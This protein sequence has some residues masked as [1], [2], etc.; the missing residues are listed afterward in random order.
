MMSKDQMFSVLMDHQAF[1]MQAHGGVSRIFAEIARHF[2]KEDL[3]LTV[4]GG[5]HVNEYLQVLQREK[6]A[7]TVGVRIPHRIGKQR[8]LMP[9]DK[10][11]LSLFCAAHRPDLIHY[12]YFH[13]TQP[14]RRSVREIMTVHD[15][16]Y[17][18]FPEYFHP[19]DPTPGRKRQMAEE[20]DGIICIS[21]N[22]KKDLLRFCDVPEERVR[23]IP[24]GNPMEGVKARRPQRERPPFFLF[25]GRR[26][27]YK[28]FTVLLDA[29]ASAVLC[30]GCEVVAFGGGPFT[31]N[32][33]RDIQSRGL[34]GCI[35]QM[36][37]PD[38]I[39]S[40]LYETAQALVYPSRYEGFG[41]PPLEAMSRGC[42]VIVSQGSSL[43]EVVGDA[44]LYF[45]PDD[46]DQLRQQMESLCTPSG[47]SRWVDK[48]LA[49]AKLFSW[50][51]CAR[52]TADFY[53]DVLAMPA[54]EY[55]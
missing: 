5:A 13:R 9:C 16:T 52:A 1:V 2:P 42:P 10:I 28:N 49:Q 48:G 38:E 36:S 41:L 18:L 54:R 23:V 24:H 14:R 35:F 33:Q 40:G 34:G 37:G 27:G 22:T 43:P 53:R 25:V 47:R 51:R 30:A 19:D 44:G 39:L 21:E 29:L 6:A 7:N 45:N 8:L 17:E 55:K 32:E 26:L 11:L 31:E 20:V 50:T 3:D 12:T 46:A 4:F 15:M